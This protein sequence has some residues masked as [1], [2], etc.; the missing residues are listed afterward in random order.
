MHFYYNSSKILLKHAALLELLEITLTSQNLYSGQYFPP[1]SHTTSQKPHSSAEGF[2]GFC[3]SYTL[4][5]VIL[6]HCTGF[7]AVFLEWSFH[8]PSYFFKYPAAA[9]AP[10][11]AKHYVVRTSF[12]TT[13]TA[14][15]DSGT[16][17]AHFGQIPLL[18]KKWISEWWIG[19]K[20]HVLSLQR[21]LFLFFSIWKILADR[22]KSSNLIQF[23]FFFFTACFSPKLQN[24]RMNQ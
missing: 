14:S 7:K 11:P 1:A 6:P 9:W 3:D 13:K 22:I 18:D 4:P 12:D 16:G 20:L 23:L 5:H 17:G 24:K 8:C 10:K 2:R 19:G 15:T 21:L